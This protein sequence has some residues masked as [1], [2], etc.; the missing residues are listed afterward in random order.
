MFFIEE[1]E[2]KLI[3]ALKF[4]LKQIIKKVFL[5][6]KENK[7]KELLYFWLRL[8]KKDKE[9]IEKANH[10]AENHYRKTKLKKI[11]F[12]WGKII[13]KRRKKHLCKTQCN[14]FYFTS[15][16]I[17]TFNIMKMNVLMNAKQ[18]FFAKKFVK[19][20]A[21]KVFVKNS[22]ESIRENKK[23][24]LVTL[25]YDKILMKKTFDKIVKYIHFSKK[26]AIE[27]FIM[28][29]TFKKL[30]IYLELKNSEKL[31]NIKNILHI[32][33]KK[34]VFHRFAIL[35][36]KKYLKQYKEFQIKRK[37]FTLWKQKMNKEHLKEQTRQFLLD[38]Y[39][40]NKIIRI[41]KFFYEAV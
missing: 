25:Y 3:T 13:E 11:L 34:K 1:K 37:K 10:H 41:V 16:K 30:R 40:H 23:K 29:K 32:S 7:K 35:V 6:V 2:R 36:K 14:F 17:K 8:W 20:Y 38:E 33:L 19:K 28:K 39:L 21:F 24:S 18:S 4:R 26:K 15:L 12:S 9:S 31:K 22:K 27:Y 5:A